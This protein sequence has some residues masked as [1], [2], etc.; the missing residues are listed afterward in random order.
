MAV[1]KYNEIVK[2]TKNYIENIKNLSQKDFEKFNIIYEQDI[3]KLES[4]LLEIKL[5][6]DTKR[7]NKLLESY[8][9]AYKDLKMIKL[10]YLNNTSYLC[11]HI[12]DSGDI[13]PV[14]ILPGPLKDYD[15]VFNKKPNKDVI[16]N[17]VQTNL[18]DC[19]IEDFSKC[20]SRGKNKYSKDEILQIYSKCFP[21]KKIKKSL[22][23][24][25]MCN[26][27]QTKYNE[28]KDSSST[29]RIHK[30]ESDMILKKRKNPI[31]IKQKKSKKCKMDN[32]EKCKGRGKKEDKYTRDHIEK[33]YEKC[34]GNKPKKNESVKKMC[35]KIKEYLNS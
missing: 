33:V 29:R 5:R 18:E 4:N 26:E 16:K 13:N 32:L 2:N 7:T 10:S 17:V 12:R 6:L 1:K 30:K 3:D 24:K 14:N 22:S 19:R 31:K 11:N 9:V 21:N 27:I 23:I 20:K 34:F 8:M 35:I 25:K 28:L 15:E